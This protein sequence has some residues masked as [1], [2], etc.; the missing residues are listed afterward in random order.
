MDP[1]TGMT[2]SRERAANLCIGTFS[3][4]FV[5]RIRSRAFPPGYKLPPTRRLATELKPTAPGARLRRSRAGRVVGPT[6]G[7]RYLRARRP[8]HPPRRRDITVTEEH[9]P[10]SSGPARGDCVGVV[11]LEPRQAESLRAS[12]RMRSAPGATWSTWPRWCRPTI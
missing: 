10:K 11:G 12:P 6:G 7:A 2:P 9:P 5:S 8:T 3:T 1:S 4:R